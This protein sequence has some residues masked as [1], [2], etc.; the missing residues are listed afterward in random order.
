LKQ[1]EYVILLISD[2]SRIGELE[3][4]CAFSEDFQFFTDYIPYL[5]MD[6]GAD[7]TN[8]G[9]TGQS[10]LIMAANQGNWRIVEAIFRSKPYLAKSQNIMDTLL[11]NIFHSSVYEC[12]HGGDKC[13][14][15]SNDKLELHSSG[16]S[17]EKVL[18]IMFSRG[19]KPTKGEWKK[20]K[21]VYI[22]KGALENFVEG[23]MRG[24][25]MID[26]G[27]EIVEER[28]CTTCGKGEQQLGFP[29]KRCAACGKVYYCSKECQA[30]DWKKN[31]KNTCEG[32]K[33]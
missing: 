19:Y 18:Q 22:Y 23:L 8:V 9:L 21:G 12:T 27:V 29:L 31:H 14:R 6:N 3:N 7:V 4:S 13:Q 5:L 24:E 26:P 33:K 2:A 30:A 28:K 1:C 15:C 25:N 20:I 10:P 11:E 32:K 17:F 16:V